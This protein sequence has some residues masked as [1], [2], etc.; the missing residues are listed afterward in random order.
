MDTNPQKK[1]QKS[2]FC[3]LAKGGFGC[4]KVSVLVVYFGYFAGRYALFG[5]YT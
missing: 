3:Q 2:P 1:A 4:Y 5:L